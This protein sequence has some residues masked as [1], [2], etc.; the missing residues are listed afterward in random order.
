[1]QNAQ[2]AC[3]NQDCAKMVSA[4]VAETCPFCHDVAFCGDVCMTKGFTAHQAECNVYKTHTDAHVVAVPSAWQSLASQTQWKTQKEDFPAYMVQHR[5]ANGTITQTIV[6]A[7]D[8]PAPPVSERAAQDLAHVDEHGFTLT[9]EYLNKP[10]DEKAAQTVQYVNLVAP[11][12]MIHANSSSQLASSQARTRATLGN[13][14]TY[15]VGADVTANRTEQRHKYIARGA[16][17]EPLRVPDSGVAHEQIPGMVRLTLQTDHS[18]KDAH[19]VE[20]LLVPMDDFEEQVRSKLGH[21]LRQHLQTQY[22]HKGLGSGQHLATY[23]AWNTET[24]ANAVLTF[25]RSASAETGHA[26]LVDVEFFVPA[27]GKK[28][29]RFQKETFEHTADM[30]DPEQVD[31]LIKAA[32]ERVEDMKYHAKMIRKHNEDPKNVRLAECMDQIQGLEDH[33]GVLEKYQA[34]LLKDSTIPVSMDVSASANH[35]LEVLWEPI[36]ARSQKVFDEIFRGDD[37]YDDAT[38]ET[39]ALGMALIKRRDELRQMREESSRRRGKGRQIVSNI[40]YKYIERQIN[41]KEKELRKLITAAT[42]KRSEIVS[43]LQDANVTDFSVSNKYQWIEYIINYASDVLAKRY[44]GTLEEY[45]ADLRDP[46]TETGRLKIPVRKGET[47]QRAQQ[48][49]KRFRDRFSRSD[50]SNVPVS[51]PE[52]GSGRQGTSTRDAFER[53]ENQAEAYGYYGHDDPDD[54]LPGDENYDDYY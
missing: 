48:F 10:T 16:S 11:D 35:M 7:V 38:A 3:A 23:M 34:R 27:N 31:S 36:E 33:L 43:T 51:W 1:M 20:A 22:K 45:R 25:D 39:N 46:N 42:V 24:G 14:Y 8:A 47:R 32:T 37:W 15:W 21:H 13:G 12:H 54:V 9:A 49:A 41:D 28:P 2:V 44:S 19:V 53:G 50:N 4:R 30:A 18:G 17:A 40:R 6:P 29:L 5:N 26:R 52:A